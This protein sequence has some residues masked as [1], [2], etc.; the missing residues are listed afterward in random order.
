MPCQVQWKCR[1]VRS[2]SS[3]TFDG[4]SIELKELKTALK[5]AQEEVANQSKLR[6]SQ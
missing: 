1:S 2:F 6:Y 4:Q 5:K 3:V